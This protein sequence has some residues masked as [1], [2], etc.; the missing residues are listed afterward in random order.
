MTH[1]SS[2]IKNMIY[3]IVIDKTVILFVY[4]KL[5]SPLAIAKN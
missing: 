2:I 3:V 4:H 5:F 1:N